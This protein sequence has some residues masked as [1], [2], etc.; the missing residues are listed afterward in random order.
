MKDLQRKRSK[1][2]HLLNYKPLLERMH[3][4][5]NQG[6]R[7]KNKLYSLHAPEV[8]CIAKGKAHKAYE[9]GSKM[10]VA[11]VSGSNVVVSMEN[12]RGNPHDGKTLIKALESVH[13]NCGKAFEEV[14]VDRGYVGHGVK[15]KTKVLLP[16]SGKRGSQAGSRRS[17]SGLRSSIEA[18]ISHLKHGHGLSR[19]YLKGEIG[20]V[21]NGLLSGLG[22]NMK[23][24]ISELE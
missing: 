19:N 24:L 5:V 20:D 11:S 3:G 9:L 16:G 8:S 22:W 23:L 12:F 17:R 18:L 10:S 13:A 21:M 1:R 4:A 15:G 6:R 2:K 7:D 14:L